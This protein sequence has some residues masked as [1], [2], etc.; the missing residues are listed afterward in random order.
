MARLLTPDAPVELL[1][2][3]FAE[4]VA[5]TCTNLSNDDLRNCFSQFFRISSECKLFDRFREVYD[6]HIKESPAETP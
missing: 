2:E 5:Q 4:G 6:G 1:V 3:R